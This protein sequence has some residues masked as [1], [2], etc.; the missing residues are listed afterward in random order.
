MLCENVLIVQEARKKFFLVLLSKEENLFISTG[1][2]FKTGR[3]LF[4]LCTQ[5]GQRITL[6]HRGRKSAPWHLNDRMVGL[7]G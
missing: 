5:D 4:R 6:D 3:N 1:H 2:L 7:L